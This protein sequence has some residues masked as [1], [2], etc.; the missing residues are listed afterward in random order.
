MRRLIWFLILAAAIYIGVKYIP[1]ETKQKTLASFGLEKFFRETAPRYLR[2]KLSILEDPVSKRKKVLDQIGERIET[3]QLEL[4]DLPPLDSKGVARPVTSKVLQ[5]KME[6][7]RDI[8][9]E[10]QAMLGELQELNPK[11]GIFQEA[12]ER[13]LD[14]ILPSPSAGTISPGTGSIDQAECKCPAQ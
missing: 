3:V 11:G 14:K 8:L 10:T 12:A 4:K 1:A 2:E 5:E 6:E 9:G 7:T 13:V